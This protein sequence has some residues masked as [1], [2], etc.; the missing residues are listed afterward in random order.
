MHVVKQEC[1]HAHTSVCCPCISSFDLLIPSLLPSYRVSN[2][3]PTSKAFLQVSSRQPANESKKDQHTQ[4][5]L[6]RCPGP[7]TCLKGNLIFFL[8]SLRMKP[9]TDSSNPWPSPRPL[10]LG[11]ACDFSPFV[12]DIPRQSTSSGAWHGGIE[13]AKNGSGTVLRDTARKKVTWVAR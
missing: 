8:H 5:I 11:F 3:V 10:A 7:E 6:Q 13:G 4:V 9:D 2:K 1:V 12:W